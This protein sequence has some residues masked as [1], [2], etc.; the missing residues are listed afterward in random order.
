MQIQIGLP[1]RSHNKACF[2]GQ[3]MK[4]TCVLLFSTPLHHDFIIVIFVIDVDVVVTVVYI[5]LEPF[6][7]LGAI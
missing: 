7:G 3:N 1:R 4:L 5:L 2:K 6:K